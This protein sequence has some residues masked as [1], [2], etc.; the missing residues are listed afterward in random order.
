MT[1]GLAERF[2]ASAEEWTCACGRVNVAGLLQTLVL[3]PD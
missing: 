1:T 2:T 3:P